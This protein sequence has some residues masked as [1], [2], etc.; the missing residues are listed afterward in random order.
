MTNCKNESSDDYLPKRNVW[1]GIIE[2]KL[3]EKTIIKTRYA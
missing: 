3:A 2:S 1:K